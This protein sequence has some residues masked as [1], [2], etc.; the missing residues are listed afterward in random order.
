MTRD[1][2]ACGSNKVPKPRKVA[3]DQQ[4]TVIETDTIRFEARRHLPFAS[5]SIIHSEGAVGRQSCVDE[6]ARL[7][8]RKSALTRIAEIVSASRNEVIC[9]EGE[10]IS[11]NFRVQ[12]GGVRVS[13]TLSDG[14]RHVVDFLFPG[15]F[16][17]FSE[18]DEHDCTVEA[19]LPTIVQRYPRAKFELV[20]RRDLDACNLLRRAAG[21][22][23]AKAQARCLM[24]A[25]LSSEERLATFL[26]DMAGRA[27]NPG[28]QLSLQMTRGDIGDYLGLTIETVSR[29][30]TKFRDRDWIRMIDSHELVLV[31]LFRLAELAGSNVSRKREP[32]PNHED[33]RVAALASRAPAIDAQS[34]RFGACRG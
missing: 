31:N 33:R 6:V 28:G 11:A 22:S 34:S 16:F 4:L 7:P 20:A 1:N 19:L 27:N 3:S 13:K 26:L 29:T 24:L 8:V 15:D 30:F 21:A 25:R 32:G 18:S 10:A 23:L 14:R 2:V 12:S 17:G 9:R 5:R